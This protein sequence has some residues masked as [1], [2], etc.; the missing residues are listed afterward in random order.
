MPKFNA[1]APSLFEP[2]EVVI[3]GKTYK[4]K[5]VTPKMMRK[6]GGM[7]EEAEA[8]DDIGQAFR[9]AARQLHMFLGVPE[10]VFEGTDMRKLTSAVKFI[11]DTIIDQSKGAT[12]EGKEQGNGEKK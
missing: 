7:F 9:L 5:Q 12:E 10:S 1:D 6:I 3:D 8:S 11:T 4:V 2:I